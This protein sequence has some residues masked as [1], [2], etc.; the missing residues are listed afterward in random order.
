M[1]AVLVS[2]F[3]LCWN[4]MWCQVM[5][6]LIS[7]E[8]LHQNVCFHN[9]AWP[10]FPTFYKEWK[11]DMC[12]RHSEV[13]TSVMKYAVLTQVQDFAKSN[14]GL[15]KPYSLET[16]L[17]WSSQGQH[18]PRSLFKHRQPWQHTLEIAM[19]YEGEGSYRAKSV[20][21]VQMQLF[22]AHIHCF[23]FCSYLQF[24]SSKNPFGG[25]KN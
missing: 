25:A 8:T 16:N 23:G 19:V 6:L 18:H 24:W 10:E 17:V 2:Q 12:W 5:C 9:R 20:T 13:T 14:I 21:G 22:K 4:K 15:T 7:A 1:Q 3:M 11:K